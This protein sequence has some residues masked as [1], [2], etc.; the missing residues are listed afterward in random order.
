MGLIASLSPR[1]RSGFGAG[2]TAA[3]VTAGLDLAGK[4]YLLTGC[5]SGIGRE[6]LRVLHLRGARVLAGTSMSRRS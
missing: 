3:Q 2:A 5:T 6:T 1:G 4:T